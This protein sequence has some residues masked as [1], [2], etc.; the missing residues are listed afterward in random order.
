MAQ[1]AKEYAPN[2]IDVAAT[3]RWV[4]YKKKLYTRAISLFEECRDRSGGKNPAIIY[5][6]GMAYYKHGD[7]EKAVKALQQFLS[8]VPSD[9]PEAKEARKA[10][11]SLS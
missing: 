4:Y 7:K 2:R 10:L 8:K 9:T 1:K 5:H 3:R 6:L 11:D